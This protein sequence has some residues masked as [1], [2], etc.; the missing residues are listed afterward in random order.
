M[1]IRAESRLALLCAAAWIALS[2]AGCLHAR[3]ERAQAAT[4]LAR[5]PVDLARERAS[6]RQQNLEYR[7]HPRARA[8]IAGQAWEGAWIQ[9]GI[10]DVPT[11]ICAQTVRWTAALPVVCTLVAIDH[12]AVAVLVMHEPAPC[13]GY[14]CFEQSWVF[15]R[16]YPSP[17]PLPAR[18]ASDYELLRAEVSNEAATTLWL[19]GFRAAELADRVVS[20]D[21]ETPDGVAEGAAPPVVADYASCALSPDERELLCRSQAGD[22]VGIDP[23]LGAQRLI[24]RL[25][26]PE[27]QLPSDARSSLTSEP[28]SFAAPD[29]LTFRVRA[30]HHPL[31]GA[32]PCELVGVV[33]WPSDRPLLAQLERVTPKM[34]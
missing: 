14:Q 32:G 18:R 22:V 26:V 11:N 3:V 34:P 29:R 31:C 15:L 5:P 8:L 1:A 28:V 4:A 21:A 20:N 17:L 12:G 9:S 24:A 23:L 6:L 13:R 10:V 7:L 19:A 25:G 30:R 16:T 33:P 2:S 27:A